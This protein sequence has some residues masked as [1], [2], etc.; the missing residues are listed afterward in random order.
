[1]WGLDEVVHAVGGAPLFARIACTV[2]MLAPLGLCLGAFMPMGLT[3]VARATTAELEGAY[4]AWG[5]AANGFF[6]V[7][8]SLLVTMLSMAYG[9][10]AMFLVAVIL[11][12]DASVVLRLL[13]P[14]PL[15]PRTPS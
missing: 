8:G 9:F 7:I 15:R 3:T 6:S 4:V 10:R 12:F 1:M 14:L 11:Y 5:W 2:V 13:P